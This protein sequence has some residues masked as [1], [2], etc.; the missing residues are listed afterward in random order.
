MLKYSL[1]VGAAQSLF[2]PCAVLSYFFFRSIFI[3]LGWISATYS[4]SLLVS[5]QIAQYKQQEQICAVVSDSLFGLQR[6]NVALHP[7]TYKEKP[8]CL[9]KATPNLP[10]CEGVR[11]KV[12][13]E[14]KWKGILN[15]TCDLQHTVDL[16]RINGI[17]HSIFVQT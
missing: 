16:R 14:R 11:G 5:W 13:A 7:H 10:S 12:R 4:D 9:L 3:L 15:S 2:K 1:C 17:D 6:I 8:A